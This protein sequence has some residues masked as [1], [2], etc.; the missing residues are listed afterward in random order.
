MS[1]LFRVLLLAA[2]LVPGAAAAQVVDE[3]TRVRGGIESPIAL[4]SVNGVCIDLSD[5]ITLDGKLFALDTIVQLA[6][7]IVDIEA[8]FNQDPFITFGVATTNLIPGPL[9]YSFLFATP[10]VPGVYNT[11][12]STGGVT[13]TNAPGGALSVANSGIY[14]TYISGYGTVGIAPTNL[15][16]DLG[17]APCTATGPSLS[18]TVCNQGS[19]SNTFAPTF[20]DNLEALLT[21]TQ[22]GL[23]SVAW[24]GGVTLDVTRTDTAVPEPVTVTLLAVS[25]FALGVVGLARRRRRQG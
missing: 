25:A 16:V 7:A 12:S 8:V 18:T 6:A 23:G 4:L 14:P 22:T 9:T 11:A 10:I 1:W 15:G 3:C 21:Y 13:V 24:S 19:A 20:Y 5:S 17:T 2:L